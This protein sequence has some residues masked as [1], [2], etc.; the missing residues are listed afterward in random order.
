[1][2]AL[3]TA[4]MFYYVNPMA[5]PPPPGPHHGGMYPYPPQQHTFVPPPPVT[6]TTGPGQESEEA[7]DTSEQGGA[8]EVA[9]KEE[10]A[11]V[12]E[13]EGEAGKEGEE[14]TP[15]QVFYLPMFHLPLTGYI[16]L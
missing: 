4:P 5:G 11:A 14:D 13:A 15:G 8:V 9:A 16:Y 7:M 1:M 2:A 10:G 6:M 3:W 12:E